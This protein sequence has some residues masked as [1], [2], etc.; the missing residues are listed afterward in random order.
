MQAKQEKLL[1][2]QYSLQLKEEKAKQKEVGRRCSPAKY[3]ALNVFFH[4]R[5]SWFYRTRGKGEKIIW[6]VEQRMNAKPR[7]CKWYVNAFKSAYAEHNLNWY[8]IVQLVT[9][10][11]DVL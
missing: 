9:Q 10:T 6:S 2:K 4:R 8:V 1:V 11:K 5:L 7:L 3:A